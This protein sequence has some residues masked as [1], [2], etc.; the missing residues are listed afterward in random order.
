ME[1]KIPTYSGDLIYNLM[2]INYT[3]NYRFSLQK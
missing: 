1:M 3:T 2:F